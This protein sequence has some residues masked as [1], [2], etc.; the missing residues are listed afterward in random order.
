M[1][2]QVNSVPYLFLF[3]S[4]IAYFY[5]FSHNGQLEWQTGFMLVPSCLYVY[6]RNVINQISAMENGG[7][8]KL[9]TFLS[10]Y[11][12]HKLTSIPVKYNSPAAKLYK[13]RYLAIYVL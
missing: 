2:D 4:K 7:N 9:N 12:V 3:V 6:L 8:N 5:D 11:D 10:Q 1:L 13:D